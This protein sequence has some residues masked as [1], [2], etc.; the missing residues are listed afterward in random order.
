M[1][2]LVSLFFALILVSLASAAGSERIEILWAGTYTVSQSKEVVDPNAPSGKRFLSSDP[3]LLSQT[4]RIPAVIGTRFG[5]RFRFKE[6]SGTQTVKYRMVWRF[7]AP[8]IANPLTGN[9]TRETALDTACGSNSPCFAGYPLREEFEVVPGVW[10][11]EIWVDNS[12]ALEHSF[13]VY[14]P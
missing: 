9:V 6:T 13:E 14:R 11:V 2:T 7:P 4:S 12:K 5:I 3:T 1:R 10:T 8:G